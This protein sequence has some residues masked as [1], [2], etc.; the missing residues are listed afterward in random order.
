M[1][2][3]I[4]DRLR[5]KLSQHILMQ[6][7]AFFDENRAGEIVSRFSSDIAEYKVLF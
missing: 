2:E 3:R 7:I 1:G 6:E 4:A 5:L